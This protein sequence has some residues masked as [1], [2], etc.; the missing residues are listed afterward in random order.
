MSAITTELDQAKEILRSEKFHEQWDYRS[1][2]GHLDRLAR[3]F[4]RTR[5]DQ[6]RDLIAQFH[7]SAGKLPCVLD[8]DFGALVLEA[9]ACSVE[10]RE[11]RAWLYTEARFRAVWCSQAGTAGG[12]CI[13]RYKHV[14]RLGERLHDETKKAPG[15]VTATPIHA[16]SSV[17]VFNGSNAQ[18]PSG[19]F[20]QRDV[21]EKWIRNHSLSGTLTAYPIEV[22]AFDWAV[23]AGHF[24]P[25]FDIQRS[26]EFIQ[27]FS[28]A[29]QEHYHYEQGHAQ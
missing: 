9:A 2:V 19:V 12:E 24:T 13:A 4:Q 21:A 15:N 5:R 1:L 26:A 16:L 8:R 29:R 23:S 7:D 28:S 25:D 27:R 20:T 10:D 18:F 6:H 14:M 17:W 22:G 11:L 3:M